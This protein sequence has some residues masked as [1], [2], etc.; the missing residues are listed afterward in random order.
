MNKK[1]ETVKIREYASFRVLAPFIKVRILIPQPAI[2]KG[3][4]KSKQSLVLF[5]GRS[6]GVPLSS[7]GARLPGMPAEKSPRHCQPDSFM[8]LL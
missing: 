1:G 3:L 7:G 6:G 8:V 4:P 2:S 5:M